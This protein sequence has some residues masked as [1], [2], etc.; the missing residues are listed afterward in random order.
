MPWCDVAEITL[1][2]CWILLA[3][4]CCEVCARQ[5]QLSAHCFAVATELV[6]SAART[7]LCAL[8]STS[9]KRPTEALQAL[10]ETVQVR[11]IVRNHV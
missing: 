2:E 7:R 4:L 3:S 9:T 6:S 11:F 5:Q 8:L 10:V 1:G